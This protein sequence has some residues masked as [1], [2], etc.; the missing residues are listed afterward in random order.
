MCAVLHLSGTK[1]EQ[2]ITSLSTGETH[3]VK[4]NATVP[5]NPII[6]IHSLFNNNLCSKT[7]EIF[8]YIYLSLRKYSF[9]YFLAL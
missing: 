5:K 2:P 1:R 9:E 3:I 8:V 7:T 4:L 6:F